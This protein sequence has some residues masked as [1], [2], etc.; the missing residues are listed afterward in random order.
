MN[1][2]TSANN[3]PV[4]PL[5]GRGVLEPRIPSDRHRDGPSVHK[6]DR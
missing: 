6:V 3:A 4:V 1:A 5:L 2:L